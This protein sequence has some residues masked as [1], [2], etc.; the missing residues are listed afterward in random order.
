MNIEINGQTKNALIF[1]SMWE[2]VSHFGATVEDYRFSPALYEGEKKIGSFKPIDDEFFG[3][4]SSDMVELDGTYFQHVNWGEDEYSMIPEGDMDA[5]FCLVWEWNARLRGY[6]TRG[7]IFR[8]EEDAA[9]A[10]A[11]TQ[12]SRG[13]E[14]K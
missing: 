10:G 3:T 7:Q 13:D 5:E 1:D 2:Y 14:M 4:H 11:G 6:V 12:V 9:R 8:T